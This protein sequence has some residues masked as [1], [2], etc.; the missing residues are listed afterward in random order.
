MRIPYAKDETWNKNLSYLTVLSGQQIS[1][2]I[3]LIA[4]IGNVW[5]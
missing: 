1:L 3:L 5:N 2:P 4:L